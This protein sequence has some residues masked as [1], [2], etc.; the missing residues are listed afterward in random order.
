VRN[1]I[2]IS[3]IQAANRLKPVSIRSLRTQRSLD[4][5]FSNHDND[6]WDS[7]QLYRLPHVFSSDR[8]DHSDHKETQPLLVS[9]FIAKVWNWWHFNLCGSVFSDGK[10][11]YKNF[12]PVKMRCFRNSNE[13]CKIKVLWAHH[14]CQSS[15]KV[16]FTDQISFISRFFLYL[17]IHIKRHLDPVPLFCDMVEFRYLRR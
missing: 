6:R 13:T 14:N 7:L 4:K 17:D 2:I 10:K 8:S 9:L 15:D 3:L 5:T 11:N 12:I 16:C 1:N